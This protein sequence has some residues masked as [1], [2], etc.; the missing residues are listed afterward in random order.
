MTCKHCNTPTYNCHCIKCVARLILTL[1]FNLRKQSIEMQDRF[2]IDELKAEII[3]Q[4]K[5][6]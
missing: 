3:E 5:R 6:K 2:D 4:D 1:P